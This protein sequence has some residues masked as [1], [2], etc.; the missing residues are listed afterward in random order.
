[1]SVLPC[2]PVVGRVTVHRWA[3]SVSN[4]APFPFHPAF[5]LVLDRKMSQFLCSLLMAAQRFRPLQCPGSQASTI[6]VL[7]KLLEHSVSP[8]MTDWSPVGSPRP[9]D[10][11]HSNIY[12]PSQHGPVCPLP[13]LSTCCLP[14]S[15]TPGHRLRVAPGLSWLSST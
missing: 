12:S 3:S 7:L 11:V 2:C 5:V 15:L 9:S 6:L 14:D 4:G 8:P 10:P 13:L 1:M